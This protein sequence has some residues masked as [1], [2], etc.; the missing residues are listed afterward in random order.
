MVDR[1]AWLLRVCRCS[2]YREA[3]P[4]ARDRV[5]CRCSGLI[6]SGLVVAGEAWPESDAPT[7]QVIDGDT[8]RIGGDVVRIWGIDAPEKPQGLP[9]GWKTY[10]CGQRAGISRITGSRE[11]GGVPFLSDDRYGRNV[12]WCVIDGERD[13][14]YQIVLAGWALDYRRYSDGHYEAPEQRARTLQ[15]GMW[16]GPFVAPW[17]WRRR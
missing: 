9:A 17:D 10:A 5:A 3:V 1:G 14:A 4:P 7:V 15:R 13:L 2:P 12:S 6:A 16:A 11:T 8:L